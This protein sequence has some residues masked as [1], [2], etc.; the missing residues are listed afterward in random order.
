MSQESKA[1]T[2]VSCAASWIS[3]PPRPFCPPPQQ[4]MNLHIETLLENYENLR[5]EISTL[6]SICSETNAPPISKNTSKIADCRI[7][8]RQ[9]T[10]TSCGS[11]DLNVDVDGG[12]VVC[13]QCGMIQDTIVFESASTSAIYHT[14]VSRTVA[15]RYS[16]IVVVRGVLRSLQGETKL[17]FSPVKNGEAGEEE[18]LRSFFPSDAPPKNARQIKKAINKL[19][20]PKRLHH[21]A[22]TILFRLWRNPTPNPSEYEIR[23]VLHK[24][25]ALENGWDR[26]PLAGS[27]RKGRKKF[28]SLPLVWKY[29]CTSLDYPELGAIMDELQLKNAKNRSSQTEVL[30]RLIKWIEQ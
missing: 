24:F 12:S 28:L 19:K 27:I 15:H 3:S 6:S 7:P 17:L 23:N 25:R 5:S 9:C 13:F 16:R 21:H 2:L 11:S 1:P 10:A 4:S 26:A 29:L 18:K 30:T 22:T 14:G 8:A 20:L